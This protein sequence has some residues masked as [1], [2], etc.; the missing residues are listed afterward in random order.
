MLEKLARPDLDR[1]LHRGLNRLS[2]ES[3]R[4]AVWLE[5]KIELL[6]HC[7]LWLCVA[8]GGLKLLALAALNPEAVAMADLPLLALPYLLIALAPIAGP[9]RT[10]AGPVWP[11]AECPGL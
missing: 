11:L 7:W 8:L 9:T 4:V 2:A 3:R 6:L 5:L 1:L 10:A